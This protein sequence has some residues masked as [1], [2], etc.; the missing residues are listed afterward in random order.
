[1]SLVKYKVGII[2]TKLNEIVF[3]FSQRK[4]VPRISRVQMKYDQPLSGRY[5]GR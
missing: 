5:Q 4:C 2:F 1:M 3:D